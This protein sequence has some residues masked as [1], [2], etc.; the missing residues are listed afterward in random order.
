VLLSRGPH[1][2]STR[3]AVD[4]LFR[5]AALAYGPMV[6]GV[7][8]TGHLDDG[9]AGLM[10]IKGGG[11]IAVVQEPSEASAPS[12]PESAL[13]H[14]RKVDHCCKVS[15]M[16]A[17]FV[18]LAGSDPPFP[19]EPSDPILEFEDRISAATASLPD[20]ELLEQS[21]RYCE[22]TCPEY[23]SSPLELPHLTEVALLRFRCR[24]G[25]GFRRR[26]WYTPRLPP[27]RARS[28]HFTVGCA[29]SWR[30]WIAY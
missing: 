23:H 13:R 17:L 25:H 9:T 22:L 21:S 24:A 16:A 29:R 18:Q 8:L 15:E 10:T 5:S 20:W 11:G 14:V 3:P 4:V 1:E 28:P 2:N 26:A 12:M 19:T 27:G 7:V 6:V 30:W